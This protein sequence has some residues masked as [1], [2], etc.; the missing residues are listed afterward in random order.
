MLL[1]A[2]MDVV[3]VFADIVSLILLCNDTVEGLGCPN[4]G[5]LWSF[6][7]SLIIFAVDSNL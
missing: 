6:C 7:I 4:C 2:A 3:A 1:F 5:F